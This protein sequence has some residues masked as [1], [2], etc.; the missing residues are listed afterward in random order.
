VKREN[1]EQLDDEEDVDYDEDDHEKN[2]LL[3]E[4][5]RQY[6]LNQ[7]LDSIRNQIRDE[8][9]AYDLDNQ[10]LMSKLSPPYANIYSGSVYFCFG[11]KKS[12]KTKFIFRC[13]CHFNI[14]SLLSV[15]SR[16]V[17]PSAALPLEAAR[18]ASR[19]RL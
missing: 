16:F 19:S 7:E 1:I 5:L 18:P 4:R 17:D 13:S 10:W 12:N 11:M 9:D 14:L 3:R 8:E 6:L 2:M 15:Q